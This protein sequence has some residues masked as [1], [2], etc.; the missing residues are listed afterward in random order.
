MR[1][2]SSLKKYYKFYKGSH[3]ALLILLYAGQA[4]PH[5]NFAPLLLKKYNRNNRN[6][7]LLKQ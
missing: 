3:L 4:V 2:Y 5:H 6:Y 7:T 1:I